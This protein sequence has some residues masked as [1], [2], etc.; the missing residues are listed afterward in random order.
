MRSSTIRRLVKKTKQ[1]NPRNFER[2]KFIYVDISSIDKETKAIVDPQTLSPNNAPSRAR[3]ELKTNDVLVATVRPNLNG[4]AI[5]P[6]KYNNEIAS[7][8]FC[9]LRADQDSIDPVYLFYFTQTEYFVSHLTRIAIGA[10]YPAVTDENILDTEIPLP[11]LA[12]QQRIAAILEKADR[13]RRLRRY[14]LE[15]GEGFLQGVFV[16]MFGDPGMNPKGWGT[17]TLAEENTEFVYGTSE[18]CFSEPVGLPVLRIPNVLQGEIDLAEIKYAELPKKEVNN[19]LLEHGDILFVRT[20]G[21]PDYVGRCAIFNLNRDCLF[22]SYLIRA[23]VKPKKIDPF[24]LLT[25]LRMP[26]GRQAMEPYIRT[27]AGQSNL[28]IEGLGQITLPLPP[29]F[30]QEQ[31]ARVGRRYECART[32][33]REALRQAEHL[34][35]GLLERAF[36]GEL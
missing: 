8:G 23:R 3:N 19:L 30:L 35:Q 9:V 12:E 20:N 18:K 7:T 14:A 34:F 4:V 26:M 33:Q 27:T 15:V 24:F 22:A 11:H 25:Y 16:E 6:A 31:F 13:V 32:R 29:L 10:G 36:R 5:V 21:N 2:D 28:G 17:T 1:V